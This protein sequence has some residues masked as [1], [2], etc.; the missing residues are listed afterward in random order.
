M[1]NPADEMAPTTRGFIAFRASA[2][3]RG[4]TRFLSQG[5][6]RTLDGR[7]FHRSKRYVRGNSYDQ[8][9]K[10]NVTPDG[11]RCVPRKGFHTSPRQVC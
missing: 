8:C 6:R 7:R 11:H 3:F 2:L 5:N 9:T 4:G 10:K 1:S